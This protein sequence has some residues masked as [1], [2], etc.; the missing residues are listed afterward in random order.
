M[1][2]ASDLWTLVRFEER[3]DVALLAAIR[4]PNRTYGQGEGLSRTALEA[5]EQGG[6]SIRRQFVSALLHVAREAKG[7]GQIGSPQRVHPNAPNKLDLHPLRTLGQSQCLWR[8]AM[9]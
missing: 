3:A 5:K 9:R 2:Q 4:E 6:F 8:T 1:L 7:P